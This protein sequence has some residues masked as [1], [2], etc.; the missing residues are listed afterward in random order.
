V[1]RWPQ[2]ETK[3]CY[4]SNRHQTYI[5][6]PQ[7]MKTPKV[8]VIIPV[9]NTSK[10]LK[11]CLDSI[12]NQTMSD[13]QII[14]IN[15]NSPDLEDHEIC[16]YYDENDQRIIYIKHDTNCGLGGARNTGL[17]IASG[18]YI[19]FVDSDDF[20]DTNSCEFLH[21]LAS[22]ENVD[23]VA[24]S[25]TS[26]VNG[27]L[28][29][30]QH[31]YYHY[32]RD[33]PVLDQIFTGKKFI[34]IALSCES[35]HVSACLH[36]FRSSLVN[37]FKFRENV[38]H[39][40]TDLV[41]I[42]IHNACSVYCTE[43]A[44]YYRLLREDS[45]TQREYNEKVIVDRLLSIKS[46]FEFAAGL[47]LEEDNPLAYYI[48]NAFLYAKE[49]YFG[50]ENKSDLTEDLFNCLC[51]QYDN[52][53]ILKRGRSLQSSYQNAY[54]SGEYAKLKEELGNTK[55][56][57]AH[58]KKELDTIKLSFLWKIAEPIKYFKGKLKK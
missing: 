34:E 49:I 39:E 28:N 11:K 35:F 29:L 22:E 40:D 23:I 46:L 56:A 16:K 3:A 50:Y 5:S 2:D 8:S 30:A 1:R 42:I 19:W 10:F 15:D 33:K 54:T 6:N 7:G 13:I 41:P 48:Y 4:K 17:R 55:M 12:V 27:S 58:L 37:R 51:D 21:K 18:E 43:Y 31:G 45:I 36:L 25:A 52:S 44:P 38:F 32:W 26:H 20:I 24:F 57:Y 14:I 53:V 9:Y 47:S